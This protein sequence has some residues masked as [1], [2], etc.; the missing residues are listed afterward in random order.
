M[1]ERILDPLGMS[2]TTYESPLPKRLW[3]RA[4]H[5][6]LDDGSPI[7]GGWREHRAQAVA[8]MWST[9]SDLARALIAVQK[10]YAGETGSL[11]EP[12]TVHE[13]LSPQDVEDPHFTE[14]PVFDPKQGLGYFLEGRD[15]KTGKRQRFWAWGD[16]TGYKALEVALIDGDEGAVVMTNSQSGVKITRP[17]VELVARE[18][19]W[20]LPSNASAGPRTNLH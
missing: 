4:A 16:N 8:A 13:M 5:G 18:Y 9:P 6:H 10:I 19:G 15:P 2:S 3:S 12:E 17:I 1:K 7:E 11:L 14:V 20:P